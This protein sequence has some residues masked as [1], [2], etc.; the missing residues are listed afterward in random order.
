MVKESGEQGSPYAA[1]MVTG[2]HGVRMQHDFTHD[3]AGRPGKVSE[4]SPRWLRLTRT[5]ETLTGYESADG[6]TWAA[7]GTVRL[8]G[9]P[10]TVRIGMFAA[11]PAI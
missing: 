11:S 5:G 4:R 3:T 2:E 1:V 10:D 6:V 8:A 9:L 7:V